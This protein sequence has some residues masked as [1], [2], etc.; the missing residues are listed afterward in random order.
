MNPTQR[1]AFHDEIAQAKRHI[2]NCALQAGLAH[3]ERAHII[4]QAC[5]VAHVTAHWWMCVVEWRRRRPTAVLGQLLR[6]LLGAI[7]SAVGIIPVG[8]T[9]AS[10]VSMFKRMPV[11]PGLQ[12]IISAGLVKNQRNQ[13]G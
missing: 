9:G 1:A 3:L 5:V 12:K 6:I 4:G 7:G 8:N 2:N 10:N 13:K 11:E